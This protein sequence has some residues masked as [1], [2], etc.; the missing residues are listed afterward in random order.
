MPSWH[1]SS[2]R[3]FNR[4]MCPGTMTSQRREG[5]FSMRLRG[6]EYESLARQV[7]DAVRALAFTPSPDPHTTHPQ[8]SS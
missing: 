5:N 7:E 8:V 1:E 4:V 2:R 3:T 6:A